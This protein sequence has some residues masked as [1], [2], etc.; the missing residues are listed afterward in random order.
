MN[1]KKLRQEKRILEILNASFL[2]EYF[3]SPNYSEIVIKGEGKKYAFEYE[4]D[5]GKVGKGPEVDEKKYLE[6]IDNLKHFLEKKARNIEFYSVTCST[7]KIY[8]HFDTLKKPELLIS[9]FLSRNL[10]LEKLVETEELTSE[11]AEYLIKSVVDKK[12]ILVVGDVD[13]GKTTFINAL[14][15]YTKEKRIYLAEELV[16]RS[17]GILHP[18]KGLNSNFNQLLID[19]PN[20]VIVDNPY[21]T[22]LLS[23]LSYANLGKGFIFGIHA[24]D[25]KDAVNDKLPQILDANLKLSKV[26]LNKIISTIDVIVSLKCESGFRNVD[27]IS[28]LSYDK[29]TNTIVTTTIFEQVDKGI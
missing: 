13:S 16:N 19:N 5:K 25:I 11:M 28:E 17:T 7:F 9:K 8:V 15:P 22:S 29:S 10:T 26:G 18:V 14:I 21:N 27:E 12:I 24:A 3:K 23:V 2:A 4:S 1:L 20:Y 6:L